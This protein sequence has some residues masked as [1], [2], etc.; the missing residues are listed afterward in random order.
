MMLEYLAHVL[1][2]ACLYGVVAMSLD[3]AAG[4]TG[5]VSIAHA[6]FFG[7]GAYISALLALHLQVSFLLTLL[8]A[9]AAAVALAA[10]LA[11]AANRLRGDSFVLMTLAFQVVGFNVMQ[12]WTGLTNGPRGISGIPQATILGWTLDGPLAYLLVALTLVGLAI[13]LT[14]RLTSSP[15]GRVLNA[16]RESNDYVQSLGRNPLTYKAGALCFGAG[17]AGAAGAVYAHYVGFVD[18]TTFTIMDSIMILAM[19]IIG[20]AGSIAGPLLGALILVSLPEVLRFIG[21][22]SASAATLRPVLYGAVLAGLMVIRPQGCVGK[23]SFDR[24]HAA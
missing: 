3:T 7:A 5:L 8:A 9:S 23:F 10:P 15:Y 19:V 12:N 20:G 21:V 1:I 13:W 17:L 22:P 16:I 11:L 14:H 4:R 6:V 24:S 18:P 2:L